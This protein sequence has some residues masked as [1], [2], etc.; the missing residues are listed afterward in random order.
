MKSLII[1]D[2]HLKTAKADAILAHE[3]PYDKAI[4]LNDLFDQFN[5]NA[6]DAF[7]AALWLKE[8]LKDDKNIFLWSN[9]VQ[10]YAYDF[11]DTMYCSGFTRE[12]SMRIWEVLNRDDFDKMKLYHI[13]QGVVLTHAGIS[14][15][16]IKIYS[17][18]TNINNLEVLTKWLDNNYDQAKFRVEAGA[19]HWLFGAGYNRGGSQPVGGV[20]WEDF[21]D[22]VPTKFPQIVGH[23][24]VKGPAFITMNKSGSLK[25]F[26]ASDAKDIAIRFPSPRW[27]LDLDTH[28]EHYAILEDGVL[29]IKHI[30]F[31]TPWNDPNPEGKNEIAKTDVIF[32]GKMPIV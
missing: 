1:P 22:F 26:L 30:T 23:T 21:G 32:S 3:Q 15:R 29:T 17:N 20:T 11:N 19:G 4:W 8:R 18:G 7:L 31:K 16:L 2:L 10:S 6:N 12:K 9:H 28:L 13:E 27:I 5:D 25:S 24:P 14:Q